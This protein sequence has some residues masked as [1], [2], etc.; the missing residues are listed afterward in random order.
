MLLSIFWGCKMSK[1]KKWNYADTPN[2]VAFLIGGKRFYFSYD[3]LIA[4]DGENSKGKYF[5]CVLENYWS[6][7]TGKHLNTIDNGAKD[8]RI[9][10][11]EF[12]KQ[13][14]EFLK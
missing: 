6:T 5:N 14:Q 10:Q 1:V 2:A 8:K 13:L 4:F 7:T 3:T 9:T 11:E 12:D